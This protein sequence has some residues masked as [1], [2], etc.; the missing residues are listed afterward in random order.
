MNSEFSSTYSVSTLQIR[1]WG[2]DLEAID[3]GGVRL[4]GAIYFLHV[5]HVLKM[6]PNVK[7]QFAIAGHCL[8]RAPGRRVLPSVCA[9]SCHCRHV[10]EPPQIKQQIAWH[11]I[12]Q[13]AEHE[14]ARLVY[15]KA[16]LAFFRVLLPIC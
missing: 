14:P 3:V 4:H 15:S 6:S 1:K 2:L 5:I 7:F 13:P 10:A 16:G 12:I 9:V 11:W 8:M